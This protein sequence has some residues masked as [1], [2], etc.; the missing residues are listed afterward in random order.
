M[1]K[2]NWYNNFQNRVLQILPCGFPRR[3]KNHD[4]CR[5]KKDE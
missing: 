1:I 4:I 3:K 5:E 2:A